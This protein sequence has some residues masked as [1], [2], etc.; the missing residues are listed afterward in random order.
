[1]RQGATL[2]LDLHNSK[3]DVHVT[4]AWQDHVELDVSTDDYSFI[5]FDFHILF[6]N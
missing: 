6:L 1:M 2:I 3:Y 4:T 5:N